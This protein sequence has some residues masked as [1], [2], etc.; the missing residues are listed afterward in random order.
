MSTR[1]R[2]LVGAAGSAWAVPVISRMI[3]RGRTGGAMKTLFAVLLSASAATAAADTAFTRERT[4]TRLAEG[5]YAIRHADAPDE[6]PQSNTLV[7]IG[8]REVL[9][10]DSCYMPSSAR[11]DIAQIRKWTDKPVRYLV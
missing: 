9:V 4:V 7:V 1:R 10:V 6:F 2:L 11:E 8:S 3:T 5:V